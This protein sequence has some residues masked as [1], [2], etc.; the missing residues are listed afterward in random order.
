MPHYDRPIEAKLVVRLANGEEWDATEKDFKKFGLIV[1]SKAYMRWHDWIYKRLDEAGLIKSDLTT[2]AINIIRYA[3]TIYITRGDW[4]LHNTSWCIIVGNA[5]F[6]PV[7]PATR[8]VLAA[9]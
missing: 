4:S 5:A 1:G 9:W 3:I 7:T 6:F 2:C 8:V